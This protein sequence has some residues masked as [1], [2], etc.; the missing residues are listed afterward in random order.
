MKNQIVKL[1]TTAVSAVALTSCMTQQKPLSV[2][3][4][5]YPSSLKPTNALVKVSTNG[6]SF[7]L[8]NELLSVDWKVLNNSLRAISVKN[9][10][11]KK[12]TLLPQD[13]F[14][15]T[16]KDRSPILATGMTVSDIQIKKLA[17]TN[18]NPQI[19]SQTPGEAIVATFTS[20]D[21]KLKVDW[22]AELRYGSNYIRQTVT[23]NAL[24]EDLP[25]E[26][27]VFMNNVI[28]D[29]KMVGSVSGSVMTLDNKFFA[30][31]HP[32]AE[33][34]NGSGLKHVG[35]WTKDQVAVEKGKQT[36]T[37]DITKIVN[38]ACSYFPQFVAT[39][40]KVNILGVRL[41]E[42]GKI[43][44]SDAHKGYTGEKNYWNISQID[45]KEYN[46]DAKYTMSVIL[47]SEGKAASGAI[48]INRQN[49]FGRIYCA[50]KRNS[51][52]KVG[53]PYSG[54]FVIGVYPEN[55]LRRAFL[56]Y[57]ERERCH[58]Y[59]SFLH[60]NSWYDIGYFNK[61]SEQDCLDVINAY[62]KELV[63]KRG[64]Q[65]DSLLFDDG[66]DNDETLWKFHKDFP[67]GFDNVKTQANKYGIDPG[68]WLSPWGGY[69]KPREQRIKAG[70]EQG[71]EVYVDEENS[72]NSVF[73]MS[74]PKY[75]ERFSTICK[76]MVTKYNVNHFKFDGIGGNSG[77]GAGDYAPDFEA[78][79]KLIGELRDLRSD[80]F[81]NLTTGTWPSPFWLTT[82]DSIWRGGYDH[83][84]VGKGSKRQQWLNYR[85]GM[86]YERI[87]ARAPLYPISSLMVHG[88]ILAKQAKG[89]K[90]ATDKDFRDEVRSMFGAGSQLQELYIT[91]ALMNEQKWDDL[92]ECAKWGRKNADLFI[93]THWLGGNPT[94]GEV[95]GFAAWNNGRGAITLRNPSDKEQKIDFE[96]AKFLE[97]PD[98]APRKFQIKCPFKIEF[99]DG[100]PVMPQ[101][102]YGAKIDA[103]KKYSFTLKP[104][105]VLV[106][107]VIEQ[108]V[109]PVKATK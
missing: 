12:S 78:A 63:E 31:E 16:F 81:I 9:K 91:P 102:I 74:G 20:K 72:Y 5:E 71:F 14:Y 58:P 28:S 1:F 67:Q 99:V 76:E 46:P 47:Q 101:R 15:I 57:T 85:D 82:C 53:Q 64:V 106:Y 89:L 55:Q 94:K 93:D 6:K 49:K 90:E 109:K 7:T 44:A 17:A 42:D 27:I 10:I 34:S 75:Y 24:T 107:D 84:F 38:E 60:Y 8:S 52:L 68:V 23:L 105:E 32:M 51:S 62:G 4:L 3:P 95:Y 97:L 54:S 43:V 88:A 45:L 79:L 83:E 35:K 2:T 41:E 100:K 77:S 33:N 92:A 56:Y 73:K 22:Q 37:F 26:S 86:L 25:L 30:Y 103:N 66:W 70:L 98:Y 61:Y 65:M 21:G 18:T 69:G 19:A 39:T 36:L 50:Y 13:L 108:A 104:F 29:A 87:V 48:D 80:V 11:T 40:G 59:R 96:L